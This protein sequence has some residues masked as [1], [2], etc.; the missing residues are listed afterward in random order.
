MKKEKNKNEQRKN[1]FHLESLVYQRI[2]KCEHQFKPGQYYALRSLGMILGISP[3]GIR[4]RAITDRWP[5][6][7]VWHESKRIRRPHFVDGA[8]L[9]DIQKT[10][11]GE[12]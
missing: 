1:R 3:T 4:Q 10:I 9:A 6:L 8:F 12:E 5:I 7:D 2:G 11:L